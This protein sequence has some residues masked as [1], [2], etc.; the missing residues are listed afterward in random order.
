MLS[1]LTNFN[2]I[3]LILNIP[4]STYNIGNNGW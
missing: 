2:D 3:I 4:E 1:R